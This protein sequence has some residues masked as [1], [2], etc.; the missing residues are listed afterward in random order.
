MAEASTRGPSICAPGCTALALRASG[1][2]L[3]PAAALPCLVVHALHLC[4]PRGVSLRPI[5]LTEDEIR[6]VSGLP[7]DH[8]QLIAKLSRGEATDEQVRRR[9]RAVDGLLRKLVSHCG[10]RYLFRVPVL[11]EGKRLSVHPDHCEE[12]QEVMRKEGLAY[13]I[14]ALGSSEEAPSCDVQSRAHIPYDAD[15]LRKMAL[16]ETFSVMG[17]YE[18][19]E[20]LRASKVRPIKLLNDDQRLRPADTV[21]YGSD[22]EV[23]VMGEQLGG[24]EDALE[25]AAAMEVAEEAEAA[26]E[27]GGEEKDDYEEAAAEAGEE[28]SEDGEEEEGEEE[29]DDEESEEAAAVGGPAVEA[30]AAE[31][32][33]GEEEGDYEEESEDGEEDPSAAQ[34]EK[35]KELEACKSE[36]AE[37]IKEQAKKIKKQAK[38]IKKQAKTIKAALARAEAAE[39]AAQQKVLEKSHLLVDLKAE[40]LEHKKSKQLR[41][42][43]RNVERL[44]EALQTANNKLRADDLV[45]VETSESEEEPVDSSPIMLPSLLSLTAL[46]PSLPY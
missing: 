34:M 44:K 46:I 31:E 41:K 4:L 9:P 42:A 27:E 36:Q 15:D 18:K 21:S 37:T 12:L 26:D 17:L 8:D 11:C 16:N 14:P 28:E 23:W 40:R 2:S 1:P 29:E 7:L 35:V 33:E 43:V 32:E 3:Q 6:R 5:T 38:K 30:A 13:A 20:E 25:A 45:E 10:V 19:V 24:G 22:T 39:Q